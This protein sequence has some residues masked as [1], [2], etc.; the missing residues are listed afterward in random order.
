MGKYKRDADEPSKESSSFNRDKSGGGCAEEELKEASKGSDLNG[1]FHNPQHAMSEEIDLNNGIHTIY[2]TGKQAQG[3][4]GGLQK[5]I[6]LSRYQQSS[7]GPHAVS[8]TYRQLSLV[9]IDPTY[10]VVLYYN[11][12]CC[13]QRLQLY[14]ECAEYL[15][16]STR[17]LK[18]RIKA[19]DKQE[20][21]ILFQ[22]PQKAQNQLQVLLKSSRTSTRE[23]GYDT[24]GT[25]TFSVSKK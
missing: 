18:E 13:Y 15:E 21:S 10:K 16:N 9:H 20:Q 12:A 23:D 25:G 17:A 8:Y 7:G 1:F 11:M 22:N 14:D 19:L 2:R 4:E 6:K 5:S 24:Y 3:F